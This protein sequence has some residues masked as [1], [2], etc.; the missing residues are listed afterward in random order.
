MSK[1]ENEKVLEQC[2]IY[3][4]DDVSYEFDAYSEESDAEDE[5][6]EE[7]DEYDI[8]S[9]EYDD[10]DAEREAAE[11]EKKMREDIVNNIREN[12]F[13]EAGAGAGKT[14][15]IVNRVVNQIKQGVRPE[16]LVVITFTNKAAGELLERITEA[17]IIEEKNTDIS[18]TERENCTNAVE[19]IEQMNI[20]TIHSFCYKLLQERC[21]DGGLPLDVSVLEN[22]DTSNRKK[23][24]FE[25]WYAELNTKSIEELRFAMEV[26]KKGYVKDFLSLAFESICEKNADINVVSMAET[27]LDKKKQEL[28]QL[29]LEENKYRAAL[30]TDIKDLIR[31]LESITTED[32]YTSE[33]FSETYRNF[34]ISVK[35]KGIRFAD[36]NEK[37][38]ESISTK[39]FRVCNSKQ[40]IIEKDDAK[41]INKKCADWAKQNIC[42]KNNYENWN[43]S[44]EKIKKM[45]EPYAYF[46]LIKYAKMAKQEYGKILSGQELSNDEL[47]QR[48]NELL[49]D[50]SVQEYFAK[51]YQCFYVDEFQDTD[52]IQAE[53]IWNLTYDWKKE[54]LRDGA[55]FVVGDPKQA[56]YRFRGG[57]PAVYYKIKEKMTELSGNTTIYEL[58]NNYRSG[59]EIISWVNDSFAAKF[60]NG[61][62]Q[63][64]DMRCMVPETIECEN[65]SGLT[66]LEGVYCVEQTPQG[67]K[68]NVSNK[69]EAERLAKLVYNLVHDNYGIYQKKRKE[70]KEV[71]ELRRIQYKDFLILCRNMTHMDI[72]LSEL[73]KLKIPV[74]MSGDFYINKSKVLKKFVSLFGYICCPADAKSRQ[75]AIHAVSDAE[76]TELEEISKVR[77]K[78]IKEE[79][80]GM[81]SRAVIQY[82]VKHP[83]YLL[84]YDTD[85]SE[86]ELKVI[87]SNLVK[88]T[89]EVLASA[90]TDPT[91]LLEKFIQYIERKQER[92]LSLEE[93]ANAVRF[94]N[95]HK[96]KGLE[97]MITVLVDRGQKYQE[98]S[99]YTSAEKNQSGMYDYYGKFS[100]K[101][102]NGYSKLYPYG[103]DNI[104][105]NIK[106]TAI[107]EENSENTRIEYVTATRA[108][109]VFIFFDALNKTGD[110]FFKGYKCSQKINPQLV[111]TLFGNLNSGSNVSAFSK[112]LQDRRNSE[113]EVSNADEI[114]MQQKTYIS[115]SPSMLEGEIIN[116]KTVA[117][118]EDGKM[119]EKGDTETVSSEE[120]KRNDADTVSL[121][122]EKKNDTVVVLSMEEI[123]KLSE[124][125]R[126]LLQIFGITADGKK[127]EVQERR[128]KGNI[129]G[130]VMH[131]SFE[132]LVQRYGKEI[133]TFDEKQSENAVNRC[134]CQSIMESYEDLL[135]E[136]KRLYLKDEEK[137]EIYPEAVKTYLIPVLKRF[138]KSEKIKKLFE[139]AKEIYTELPFSYNTTKGADTQLFAAIEKHLDMHKI[140]IADA[141]PVWVH[142]NAD[143]VIVGKD[144][145]INII[146]YKSDTKR[147]DFKTFE[148]ALN[149]KY[150]GQMLLYRYSMS[151]LFGVSA[152]NV[153]AELYHL[154]KE[155]E[156]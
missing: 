155:S 85:I 137:E 114:Q 17:L 97:G 118:E 154:Y 12:A 74:E 156:E 8:Y 77:L 131:R 103:L 140:E 4:D 28:E 94:M 98:A 150:E 30:L 116:K 79:T 22:E 21:F 35:D 86:E 9:E 67:G 87:Q 14:S 10:I 49:K 139:G 70:E 61:S 149:E 151:K 130:N 3:D 45:A 104:T 34:F 46:V 24:F 107:E 100:K 80:A 41:D 147:V 32:I 113:T 125:E 2:D 18:D 36:G 119:T 132:L 25:K 13:V 83:E 110:S 37:V 89:E 128:P 23:K 136:G 109:E 60:S 144:E 19:N 29:C 58:D 120:E 53:L 115:L 92:E 123:E 6:Y 57:E 117:A 47:L 102:G 62:I 133:C 141:Q 152:E 1:L 11:L 43:T 129:F 56:I 5:G 91:L 42:N 146:D 124:E 40:T 96:A 88:M 127:A 81:S 38:L 20:S 26:S 105:E 72:Y 54:K 73:K 48:A 39:T 15:L 59:A 31:Y 27:E 121:E 52:H 78:K 64:R 135:W 108:K 93:E 84:P 122:E 71:R 90:K 95:V 134:V 142:G 63:Y 126:K 75:R 138:M 101:I 99:A 82:L 55:L 143:L 145:K 65:P 111:S 51:R 112:V 69:E 66:K 106:K 44:F 76:I 16:S 33:V 7:S 148:K 153:S 50:N 68:R